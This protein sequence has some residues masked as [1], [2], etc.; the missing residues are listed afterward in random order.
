MTN[1]S[2]RFRRPDL[3]SAVIRYIRRKSNEEVFVGLIGAIVGKE[4][5]EVRFIID[6]LLPF[7]NH[8][9]DPEHNFSVSDDW[10]ETLKEYC[11]L[12]Y[13][14][15]RTR[16]L[17]FLHSHAVGPRRPSKRDLGFAKSLSDEEGLSLML[18]ANKKGAISAFLSRPKKMT[19]I[20][21][22]D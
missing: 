17:G 18:I 15:P 11:L 3:R 1:F 10:L 19:K 20:K 12:K 9:D 13:D 6:D 22:L 8:D 16:P 4:K 5:E 21:I 2:V 7:T 14:D